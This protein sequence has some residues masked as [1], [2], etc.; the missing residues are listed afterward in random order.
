MNNK[1][2][3]G[4]LVLCCMTAAILACGSTG[5]TGSAGEPGPVGPTGPQGD[6]GVPGATGATG[7][8]GAVGA[9][10][11][12]GAQGDAGA[13]GAPG[14]PGTPGAP[15]EAGPQGDKGEVGDAGH[16]GDMIC[17]DTL[18][19]AEEWHSACGSDVGACKKGQVQCRLKDVDGELVPYRTCFGEI[20]P[21][22]LTPASQGGNAVCNQDLNCDGSP[23]DTTGEGDNVTLV[24]QSV[25][26]ECFISGSSRSCDFTLAKGVCRNAK[27]HCL[28]GGDNDLC[29]ADANGEGVLW[30]DFVSADHEADMGFECVDGSGTVRTWECTVANGVASVTCTGPRGL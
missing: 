30:S 8:T 7:E 11:L 15:G 19:T 2:V 9:Q 10:G 3:L 25:Q 4:N 5:D 1:L 26:V 17:G 20:A 6:P 21:V 14:A 22:A 12:P 29:Q 16:I 13:P 27:K 28:L 24:K 18:I 23:D